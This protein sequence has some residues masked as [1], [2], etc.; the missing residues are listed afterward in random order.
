MNNSKTGSELVTDAE[1]RRYID[2]CNELAANG[3][4]E[5]WSRLSEILTASRAEC[6]GLRAAF[7]K[8][9]YSLTK[10]SLCEAEK[11]DDALYVVRAALSEKET[12]NAA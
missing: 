11:I 10:D 12:G 1:I 4:Y 5:W 8:T 7:K 9:E 2:K 3:E 6:E